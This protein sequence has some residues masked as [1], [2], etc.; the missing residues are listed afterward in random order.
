MER[1]FER[2]DQ[3]VMVVKSHLRPKSTDSEFEIRNG[4]VWTIRKGVAVSLRGFPSSDEALEA[5]ELR[6]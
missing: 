3:V 1:V 6:E 4:H 5:A 2:G